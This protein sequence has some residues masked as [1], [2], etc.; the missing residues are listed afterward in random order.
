M[1]TRSLAPSAMALSTA[2]AERWIPLGIALFSGKT[3]VPE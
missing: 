1:L 3:A 2:I